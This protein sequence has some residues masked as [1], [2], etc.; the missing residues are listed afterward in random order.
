MSN[1][2]QPGL[3]F[4][5][6]FAGKLLL[7]MS[8]FYPVGHMVKNEAHKSNPFGRRS[9][10]SQRVKTSSLGRWM[11]LIERSPQG[12]SALKKLIGIGAISFPTYISLG[13]SHNVLD[14][15]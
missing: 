10:S 11:D 8:F 14:R 3:A 5:L 6:G 13:F 1:H 9:N 12:S 15:V 7:P 2:S 4:S